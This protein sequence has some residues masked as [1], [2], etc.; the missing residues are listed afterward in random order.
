MLKWRG[1]IG[2]EI[3]RFSNMSNKYSENGIDVAYSCSIHTNNITTTCECGQLNYNGPL[4]EHLRS[5]IIIY[6]DKYFCGKCFVETYKLKSKPNYE[7]GIEIE[8]EQKK[9][10]RPVA[11]IVFGD[12]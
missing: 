9:K 7:Q 6:D 11:K 10:N 3:E 5:P 8:P 2:S 12:K 4:C 1:F